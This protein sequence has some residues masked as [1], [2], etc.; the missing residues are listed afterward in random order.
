MF[1]DTPPQG[2]DR[3]DYLESDRINTLDLPQGARLLPEIAK[4]VEAAM[5]TGKTTEVRIA[6]AEF[7]SN[8][9]IFYQIPECG[10]RVLEARPLKGCEWVT[11][12]FG[13][14]SSSQHLR[15]F[16][17]VLLGGIFDKISVSLSGQSATSV[18]TQCF[19]TAFGGGVDISLAPKVALRGQADWLRFWASDLQSSNLIRASVDAVFRF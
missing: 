14:A 19:G 8:A 12:L 5:Q 2:K 18:S 7:L 3:V 16:A 15:P 11:E 4:K 9:S 1:T 6:C 10:I 17:H 13:V